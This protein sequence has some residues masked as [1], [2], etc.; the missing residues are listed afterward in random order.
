MEK[1][2]DKE[3]TELENAS[4]NIWY[5]RITQW[6]MSQNICSNQINKHIQR[7]DFEL[8]RQYFE[9]IE[10]YEKCAVLNNCKERIL[11][12]LTTNTWN[13]GK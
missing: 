6:A 11:R 2:K 7:G 3:L 5:R 12:M 1:Y 10:E 8:L 4:M 9:Q 13:N